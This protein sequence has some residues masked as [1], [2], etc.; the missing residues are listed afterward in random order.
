MEMKLVDPPRARVVLLFP[1]PQVPQYPLW[2]PL[3]MFALATA[4][5]HAGY[6]VTLIDDRAGAEADEEL[7]R[8][9]PGALFVGVG[10]KFGTQLGNALRRIEQVK[11]LRPDVPVVVGGWFPSLFP[12]SMFEC[13]LVDVVLSG[14][15]DFNL[16]VVADRLLARASL[17]GIEGVAAREG[18]RIVSTPFCHLPDMRKTHPIPWDKVGVQRYFHPNGWTNLFTSRGCPGECTFC[19]IYCLDPKR[20]TALRAERVVDDLEALSRLGARAFKLMDTDYCADVKRIEEIA[21]EILRRG[22]EVRYEVLGRHWNLRSMDVELIRLLR[23]SGLTEIEVGVETGSQRLSDQI[24][25][26][27]DV[28]EVPATARRFT[29]N[30]IRLKVNII[31]GLPSETRA[32]LAQ[33]LRLISTLLELGDDAIRLQLFRYTPMPG[34]EKAQDDVWIAKSTGKAQLSLREL[35]DYPVI[36]MEPGRMY[37]IDEEYERVVKRLY[38]FYGPLA[39]IPGNVELDLGRRHWQ[40]VLRLL[41]PLARWRLR[42]QVFA[43]PFEKWLNDRLGFPL[44]HASDDGITPPTDTLPV[45]PMGDTFNPREPLDARLARSPGTVVS[46]DRASALPTATGGTLSASFADTPDA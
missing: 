40:R 25:K 33:T 23:R 6:A 27:L 38:Y 39:F 22:L 45:P 37:W 13:P 16:P 10:C 36:D 28:S 32:D 11:G 18:G 44:I 46:D 9:L 7:A 17:A 42:H 2:S 4:L 35:A 26:K 12:E 15:G 1:V 30:G 21:R 14:P 43:F 41:R 20:W 3:D 29:E 24:Q 5:M 19:A 8:A 34:G 31:F